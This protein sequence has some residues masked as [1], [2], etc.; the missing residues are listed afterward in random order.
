MLV[1]NI[2]IPFFKILITFLIKIST[3][4]WKIFVCNFNLCKLFAVTEILKYNTFGKQIKNR[5][6]TYEINSI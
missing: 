4:R 2:N 5:G 6:E 3:E 1:Y